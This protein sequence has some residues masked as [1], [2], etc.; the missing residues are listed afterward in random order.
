M[1]SFVTHYDTPSCH[2]IEIKVD[3]RDGSIYLMPDNTIEII[4]SGGEIKGVIKDASNSAK[5]II[6]NIPA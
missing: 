4:V 3:G 6:E 1:I 5:I 2:R